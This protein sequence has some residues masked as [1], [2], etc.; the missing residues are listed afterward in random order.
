MPIG[1][2]N[3]SNGKNNNQTYVAIQDAIDVHDDSKVGQVFT[4]ADDDFG[5][6]VQKLAI[7]SGPIV[8]SD[9]PKYTLSVCKRK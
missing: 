3:M 8:R 9:I 2:K 5:A 6:V 1:A 7:F 4:S